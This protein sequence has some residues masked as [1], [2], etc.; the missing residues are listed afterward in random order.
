MDAYTLQQDRYSFAYDPMAPT[1][2]ASWIRALCQTVRGYGCDPVILMHRAGLDVERLNVP[3]AR[4]PLLGVRRFWG[5][6]I[7][8]TNDPLLGLRVGMEVQASTLHGLGLAM[9][10]SSSLAELLT[11]VSRYCQVL[12]TTMQINLHHDQNGSILIVNTLGGSEPMHAA[13]IA[14]LAFVYRQACKLSQH[15]ISPTFV[16]LAMPPMEDIERLDEYFGVPVTM[17][18]E[19]DAIGFNYADTIEPYPGANSM[20]VKINEQAISEY[21]LRLE[22]TSFSDR[23]LLH[24]QLLLPHGEPRLVEI[25]S[26]LNLSVRTLQRKLENEGQSFLSLLDRARRTLAH[27]WLSHGELPV[28][29]IGYRLGFSDPSNFC[30]ACHRWFDSSPSAYRQRCMQLQT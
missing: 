22:R 29:E 16:T 6:A 18:A 25:A 15:G 21:L 27:D 24:I 14:T 26:R 10:A 12:S 17:G 30:R 3:E 11:L 7:E 9:M 13:R 1:V 20:L 4:Y 28:V 2:L 19:L 8:A 5:L 23:V